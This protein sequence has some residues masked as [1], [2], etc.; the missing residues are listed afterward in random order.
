MNIQ[1]KKD[2]KTAASALRRELAALNKP[3]AEITH[4]ES[5]TLLAKALGAKNWNTLEAGLPTEALTVVHGLH[6]LVEE[7]LETRESDSVA[8][9]RAR[10]ALNHWYK[11]QQM[12]PYSLSPALYPL[13]NDGLFDFEDTQEGGVPVSGTFQ[14]LEGT[15]ER[16][17]GT[18]GVSSVRRDGATLDLDYAGE[19][20]VNWNEQ[21]TVKRRGVR[22]WLDEDQNEYLESQLVLVPSGAEG[23]VYGALLAV[24]VAL[25]DAYLVYLTKNA[26]CWPNT[27]Q[28]Q[29]AHLSRIA[30]TLGFAL[31]RKEED[32]VLAQ[33]NR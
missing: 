15:C 18:A 5:L 26:D 32:V 28:A 11:T 4:S 21:R 23:D 13:V 33:F 12:E 7:L 14:L 17:R 6:L 19:T 25:V 30:E 20:F 27:E 1:T 10:L 3:V 24:R 16:L 8:S 22:V 29:R 9:D 2:A 31:T